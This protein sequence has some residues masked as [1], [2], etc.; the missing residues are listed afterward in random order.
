MESCIVRVGGDGGGA[1]FRQKSR[2]I[3]INVHRHDEKIYHLIVFSFCLMAE[4]EK[5]SLPSDDV[6]SSKVHE[7]E[8]KKYFLNTG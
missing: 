4:S 6:G 1:S 3:H 7:R 5:S 8:W 2:I